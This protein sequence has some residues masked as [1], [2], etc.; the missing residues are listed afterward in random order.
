MQTTLFCIAYGMCLSLCGNL[1]GVPSFTECYNKLYINWRDN[2]VRRYDFH[3][4]I[5]NSIKR[6]DTLFINQV[7][8]HK[9]SRDKKAV[10]SQAHLEDAIRYKRY[11]L[12][13]VMLESGSAELKQSLAVRD[14]LLLAVIDDVREGSSES[15]TQNQRNISF[16]IGQLLQ[17]N[18]RYSVSLL[19][20]IANAF[21]KDDHF[22]YF[23]RHI[24]DLKE[25]LEHCVLSS[26][27]LADAQQS[28]DLALKYANHDNTMMK[29]LLKAAL[30]VKQ[31][32]AVEIICTTCPSLNDDTEETLL[33]QEIEG[34]YPAL[35]DALSRFDIS[36]NFIIPTIPV[37]DG[38]YHDLF[39]DRVIYQRLRGVH[40]EKPV[41][42]PGIIATSK[43]PL[44]L[45]EALNY[46]MR[47]KNAYDS[48]NE[49]F[50]SCPI[51]FEA[52]GTESNKPKMAIV[53]CS[54]NHSAC[55]V[56]FNNP[57]V[58]RCPLCR[59]EIKD[60]YNQ[61]QLCSAEDY[62]NLRCVYCKKCNAVSSICA[63]CSLLPCCKRAVAP[64]ASD[65]EEI[66]MH[67]VAMV[68]KIAEEIDAY[69]KEKNDEAFNAL[70]HMEIPHFSAINDRITAFDKQIRTLRQ[71][72]AQHESVLVFRSLQSQSKVMEYKTC[73]EEHNRI[74]GE[75]N[76]FVEKSNKEKDDYRARVESIRRAKNACIEEFKSK[77]QAEIAFLD[78]IFARSV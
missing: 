34:K 67:L 64:L 6:G 37:N 76:A 58:T 77:K 72:V 48:Y 21:T 36:G 10:F 59:E 56:C 66:L 69:E 17:H 63:N 16:L 23:I 49:R 11:P 39:L 33:L 13:S 30:Q 3:D 7:I 54:Q 73:V 24:P 22:K 78:R 20:K 44:V 1:Y 75:R 65:A 35:E 25:Q 61:C 40:F 4:E 26:Q 14:D 19:D 28:C 9:E 15:D 68:E 51:C 27:S 32:N 42:R 50:T 47:L 62:D 71:K 5:S 31:Y 55:L 57:E 41:E 8:E 18:K 45:R 74:L 12:A 52:Y 70:L 43:N 38:L 60:K 53:C 2:A 29:S 46:I